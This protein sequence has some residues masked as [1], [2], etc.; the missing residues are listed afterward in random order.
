MKL[1]LYKIIA[2]IP[3]ILIYFYSFGQISNFQFHNIS[4]ENNLT[5]QNLN[6][7]LFKDSKNFVWISSP[8][9]LNRFDGRTIKR[10]TSNLTDISSILDNN[11]NSNFYEDKNNDIWFSTDNGIHKYIRANDNFT[12]YLH[13]STISNHSSAHFLVFL[14]TISDDIWY[15]IGN[16][17]YLKNIHNENLKYLGKHSL[18]IQS[19]LYPT[20]N[21]NKLL[22]LPSRDGLDY[23]EFSNKGKLLSKLS[24]LKN[25]EINSIDYVPPNTVIAG[26]K[27]GLI[28][29]DLKKNNF[30]LFKS[31]GEKNANFVVDAKSITKDKI[32]VG[33]ANNGL[34]FLTPSTGETS[35]VH[36]QQG[37]YLYPFNFPIEKIHLTNDNVFWISTAGHGIYFSS[38]RNKKFKPHL[39]G[40]ISNNSGNFIRA[41]AEDTLKNKWVLTKK[42]IFKLNQKIN[43]SKEVLPKT[44]TYPFLT[45]YP[46][47]LKFDN[48]NQCWI[49]CQKGL[50][51]FNP[52]RKNFQHITYPNAQ[53]NELKIAARINKMSN[54]KLLIGTR[55]GIFEI[56]P[57]NN[58]V[59]PYL[60][61]QYNNS[62]FSWIL[63]DTSK[64]KLIV[65]QEEVGIH[66]Y[67]SE[68]KNK[69]DTIIP[70]KSFAL[71]ISKDVDSTF[72]WIASPEGLSKLYYNSM[73]YKLIY[74]TNVPQVSLIGFLQE[75]SSRSLWFATEKGIMEYSPMDKST[76]FY[77]KIDGL[78]SLEFNFWSSFK[79]SSEENFHFGTSNGYIS[80]KPKEIKPNQYIVTPRI[81]NILINDSK[82]SK[83]L[84]CKKTKA[85]NI[86]LIQSIIQPFENN[87]LS[88]R[89]AALDYVDPDANEFR[90]RITPTE[91]EWVHSGTENFAR[92][93]NLAPG[94]YT[95]EVDAT[96]SDGI[97]SNNPAQLDI[98]ILPPW[99]QRWWFKTLVA[100]GIGGIIYLIYRNRVQQIQKE[101]DFRRKEAEYKQLTAETETAVLRLQMNPHFIFN[102]MNSISSYLLQKDIETANDYLG[103]FARLMRKILVVAEEPYLT[104]YEEMELLE[105]YM[106]AEAMRFEEKFHYEFLVDE[107]IDTYEVLIPTMILQPFVENA[108]W[109]GISNKK[110][111]GHIKI[112][113]QQN[114]KS[115]TCF[116]EDNGIGRKAAQ[117]NSTTSHESKAISI[118]KRR[119]QL[120][121][122]ENNLVVQP[123]LT[124]QDLLDK[125][126]QAIGTKVILELPII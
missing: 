126:Q 17:L 9:G 120:L 13:P 98:T 11:I 93:A 34:F 46:Y 47:D 52:T 61:P 96:N 43:T 6:F 48:K 117:K 62:F 45:D 8:L 41:F 30:K 94:K 97:W 101:A 54:G 18:N 2:G 83:E 116:I 65:K 58:Q 95:F 113:F 33:T 35:K 91:S 70:F 40:N 121:T 119:L 38:L 37:G 72:L 78:P 3:V 32:V 27:Q 56:N 15:R 86:S 25:F 109:H 22:F 50:Y 79:S 82:S 69:L 89:F 7:Y 68:K 63:E 80:F 77:N 74:D 59:T 67:N 12:H 99:W 114:P 71:Q 55:K 92:Y 24:F 104:L 115:L 64:K 14:D 87:T 105:Q 88:F 103:R 29:L 60:L 66:F 19:K 51:L 100:L 118:T 53:N 85:K 36:F 26:S 1:N 16:D 123:S 108:I 42:G 125:N 39:Q 122:T 10:F 31:F 44:A 57:T 20:L 112:G 110:G 81:T 107:G 111:I 106:Q 21:N 84:V 49:G 23:V 73:P 124:F 75:E 90:Y 76:K 5:S 28:Y 4:I 102:S